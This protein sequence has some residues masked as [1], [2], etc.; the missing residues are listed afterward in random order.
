MP[1]YFYLTYCYGSCTGLS[2]IDSM[3][4]TVCHNQYIRNHWV[5]AGLAQRGKNSMGWFFGFQLHLVIN[6]QGEL[7]AFVVIPDHVDDRKPVPQLTRDLIGKRQRRQELLPAGVGLALPVSVSRG[8]C[9][10]PTSALFPIA[11]EANLSDR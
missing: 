11:M 9:A 1:R 6:D 5:F 4:L 3:P 10:L 7:L 2:L 8:P